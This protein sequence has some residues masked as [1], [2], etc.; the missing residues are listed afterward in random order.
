VTQGLGFCRGHEAAHALIQ[1]R[2]QGVETLLDHAGT[3]AERKKPGD[4]SHPCNLFRNKCRRRGDLCV[5]FCSKQ[6]IG[7]VLGQPLW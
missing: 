6:R 3:H 2:F 1:V 5:F 4:G 7:A